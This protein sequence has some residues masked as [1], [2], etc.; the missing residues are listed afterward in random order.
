MDCNENVNLSKKDLILKL[1]EISELY[2]ESKKLEFKL[3]ALTP[4]SFEN[5]ELEIILAKNPELLSFAKDKYLPAL[6]KLNRCNN[7]LVP[8]EYLFA[9]NTLNDF[10]KANMADNI[11]KAIATFLICIGNLFSNEQ[12]L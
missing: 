12:D 5:E 11:E 1:N 8:E 6:E 7:G 3:A 10:L 9:V 2:V 4:D